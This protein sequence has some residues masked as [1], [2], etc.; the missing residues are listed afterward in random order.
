MRSKRFRVGLV[1]LGAAVALAVG[2]ADAG[3]AEYSWQQPQAKVLP[4][5]DL[6][7]APRPFD[8]E[9]G[10]SVRYIDYEG[11]EDANDGLTK[12]TPWK[13]HPWDEKATGR[14]AACSGVHTYVF[15]RGSIYRGYLLA[16]DSGEPGN[17][18]RLT[19]DPAWGNGEAALYGSVALTD[20]WKR[21]TPAD[22]PERMPEP[23]K[24]WYRDI[25]TDSV[26]RSLWER[27][28]DEVERIQVA[29]EPD[30]TISNPDDP[31]AEWF[32]WDRRERPGG[33]SV[34]EDQ[35]TQPDP[36]YYVGATVWSEYAGNMGVVHKRRIEGYDP[37]RNA[38]RPIYRGS[39]GLRYFLED[40]PQFLDGPG[41][42]YY[43]RSGEHAGRLYVR[44]SSDRDP[45]GAILEM[46]VRHYLV[47]IRDQ[48][49]VSGTGLRFSFLNA[50]EEAGWPVEVYSP[51]AVRIAGNCRHIRVANCRFSH[52]PRAVN[53]F[54]RLDEQFTEEYMPQFGHRGEADVLDDIVIAD[55]DISDT[56][57]GAISF[58]DGKMLNRWMTPPI[59]DL[60]RLKI[61]RN[62]LQRIGMRQ[63]TYRNGSIAAI[64]VSN[65]LLVE[66]AGNILDRCWGAGV[67]CY[68]AKGGDDLRDRPL[69]RILIHH[70][71]ATNTMLACNDYGGIESWQGGPAYIYDNVSGNAIGYK[72]D[73]GNT[74]AFTFYLDGQFKSYTFNNIAWGKRNDPDDPYANLAGYMQV[75]GFLNHWFNNTSYHFKIGSHRGGS[76]RSSYLGNVHTDITDSFF[77]H[78][79]T[80]EEDAPNQAYA[81]NVLY[82]KARV[83]DFAKGAGGGSLE[84]FRQR[85]CERDARACQTGWMAEEMPLRDPARDDFRPTADSA[86]LDRGVRFFVPWG[87]YAT[88]GEWHFWRNNAD[89]SLVV[90]HNFY[91]TDEYITRQQYYDVP[92]NDLRAE[93]VSP[94]SYVEGPLEDWTEGALAFDGAA[95]GCVLPDDE[96]RADYKYHIG[97]PEGES[98]SQE[99]EF[100]YPGEKRRTV[101]MDAN[102]FL[103]EV[104]F[105]TRSGHTGGTLVSKMGRDAGYALRVNEQGGATLALRSGGA[106]DSVACGGAIN[107]GAWHHLIAEADRGKGLL[108]I[109]VDGRE[110]CEAPLEGLSADASLS[111]AEDFLVGAAPDGAHFAGAVDFLRV[112]R[113]TLEDAQTTIEELYAWEFD[114]PQLRDFCGREAPPGRRDAGA[115][116][117]A[118]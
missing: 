17:P 6:E 65:G 118:R 15:K 81:N 108:R 49:H 112:C 34:D 5:G 36:D 24:V 19:S 82:G 68:N 74:W 93:G 55:N 52:V 12:T 23:T 44:L 1:I 84:D 18:I 8:F 114:G 29:R 56:D 100:V 115:I 99:G 45:N 75:I 106:T 13:H 102:N 87:L 54:A 85:L 72:A 48:S 113:G 35:L 20:G 107:D 61:L 90:G 105:K 21:C 60:R 63:G 3:A 41:E 104:H 10:D 14:A 57:K 117:L 67:L 9:K 46:P 89:P 31:Q 25:G 32:T 91:M 111:N 28:G 62:R 33:W 26:P 27:R 47:E 109:Y 42:Y 94:D 30:W 98:R 69:I 76:R 50:R 71:K 97:I 4:Q 116:E 88:V 92:R 83:G 58:I 73:V 96:L 78:R 70:N 7:W 95:T 37:T 43:A 110:R 64:G 101:D 38:V 22:A 39:K 11:G 77:L 80:P 2:V 51:A 40:L 103:I 86:A 66:V 53:G 79:H 59:G 16:D